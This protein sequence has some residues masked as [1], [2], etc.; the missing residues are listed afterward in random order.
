MNYWYGRDSVEFESEFELCHRAR[1][2]VY[3]IYTYVG[4]L[5]T[6]HPSIYHSVFQQLNPIYTRH[7]VPQTIAIGKQQ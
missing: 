2:F 4:R 7:E 6:S 3:N 1:V 5:F